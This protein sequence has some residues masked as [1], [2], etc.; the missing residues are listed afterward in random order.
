M[1]VE[2]VDHIHILVKDIEGAAKLFS[3]ILDTQ[4]IGPEKS[5]PPE[6][7][8]IAWDRK[9]FEL[10]QP[11]LP[12]SYAGKRMAE[13]GEGVCAIGIKVPDIEEAIA[14][15]KAKGIGVLYRG[16]INDLKFALT[17]WKDAY[18][19]Q[20]ELL[21]FEDVL[22]GAPVARQGLMRNLPRV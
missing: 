7:L 12:E 10:Q 21:E 22:V 19:V 1:K 4:F 16:E 5:T 3:D 13:H 8:R 18:G 20:F 2:R 17:D 6:N 14:E 9:G 11:T 15:L